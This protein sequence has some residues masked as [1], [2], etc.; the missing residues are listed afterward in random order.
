MLECAAKI[1]RYKNSENTTC[2]RLD[3]RRLL[4]FGLA[5]IDLVDRAVVADQIEFAFL[6]LGERDGALRR[7]ACEADFV[8]CFALAGEGKDVA[9]LEIGAEVDAVERGFRIAAIDV[10]AGDG[11]AVFSSVGEDRRGKFAIGFAILIGK[12]GE[13]FNDIPAV[14][15]AFFDDIDFFI[16]I[17]TDIADP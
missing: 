14:I 15:S 10:A 7:E 6:I 12:R 5:E 2:H 13:T 4:K 1:M 3:W 17:L 8:E 16:E 9:G 11:D